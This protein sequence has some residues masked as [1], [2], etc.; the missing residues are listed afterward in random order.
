MITDYPRYNLVTGPVVDSFS[1]QCPSLVFNIIVE[2]VNVE[3][4]SPAG[5][6]A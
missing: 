3:I 2:F 1:L 4:I 6:V 5:R